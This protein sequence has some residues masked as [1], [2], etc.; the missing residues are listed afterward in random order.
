[1]AGEIV[2]TIKGM[3]YT[4]QIGVFGKARTA[5]QLMNLNPVFYDIMSN[6]NYR[7]LS[8]VYDKKEDAIAAKNAIAEKG[9]KDAFI[10]VY[11][12]GIRITNSE[13]QK[14]I[15]EG[16]QTFAEAKP[17]KIGNDILI[18]AADELYFKVQIGAYR[19]ET[20]LTLRNEF[21]RTS[22][23]KISSFRTATGLIIY[24]A[25]EFKDYNKVVELRKEIVDSGIADAFI[26]A[27]NGSRKI[28]V[29]QA[30]ELLKK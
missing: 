9:I 7:Y 30:R 28:P 17:V 3:F 15:S 1:M 4:V 23:I 13:A 27:M 11:V 25:G 18:A 14:M 10:V 19:R 20:D 12:N 6:G 29:P 5:K 2:T 16:R 21:L 22:G 26:I 24:A 8:G